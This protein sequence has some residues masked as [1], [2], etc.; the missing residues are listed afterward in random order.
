MLDL[1]C[2]YFVLP[3]LCYFVASLAILPMLCYILIDEEKVKKRK[4]CAQKPYVEYEE[5]FQSCDV[6][7]THILRVYQDIQ[8]I[9]LKQYPET[10][11]GQLPYTK[12]ENKKLLKRCKK[13]LVEDSNDMLVTKDILLFDDGGERLTDKSLK[14][15]RLKSVG[16]GE[17]VVAKNGLLVNSDEDGGRYINESLERRFKGVAGVSN[18]GSSSSHCKNIEVTSEYREVTV[19]EKDSDDNTI[20]TS[21]RIDCQ[22]SVVITQ[23]DNQRIKDHENSVYYS[24]MSRVQRTIDHYDSY[25]SDLSDLNDDNDDEIESKSRDHVS[26][27]D[28]DTE[29][30]II[31]DLLRANFEENIEML[32]QQKSKKFDFYNDKKYMHGSRVK[33]WPE[34]TV[35][36]AGDSVLND[37]SSS[38]LSKK[39]NIKRKSFHGYTLIDMLACLSRL[40]RKRPTYVILHLSCNETHSSDALRDLKLMKAHVLKCLPSAYVVICSPMEQ[41]M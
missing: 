31:D 22:Q 32:N 30:D 34:E 3:Y 29:L 10:S 4:K 36:L 17:V 7:L 20:N 15:K 25:S 41:S 2:I 1:S 11:G 16:N 12:D 35:L 37:I 24:S 26:G 39:Y 18:N 28:P 14:R 40:L 19:T 27:L 5:F 13:T 21:T 33:L 9:V 8:T 23:E 6:R 38:M